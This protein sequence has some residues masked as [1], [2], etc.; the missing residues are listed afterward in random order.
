MTNNSLYP[1]TLFHFT[2]KKWLFDILKE[3][4]KVSYARETIKA[5]NN[6]RKLAVPMVS[7][8]DIKLAEIKYFIEKDYG[9]FGIGLTKDWANRNGLNPVMYINRH[10]DLADKLIDGLNGMYAQISKM[11]NIDD[12]KKMT[13]SY[14]NLM[15]MYRYVKNY[16]GELIRKGNLVDPNYRF[17][18]E[19]E[20][21]FVPPLE[22][23]GVEPFVAISN[24]T[25]KK[26]KEEYNKKVAHIKLTFEPDD[27]K[28]LFV[29]NEN[30]IS[31]LIDHLDYAKSKYS[32]DIRRRLASRILT[33]EQVQNDI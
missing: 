5:P 11:S 29:E 27:I 7:F 23:P 14:H 15:N 17:A 28:Y 3:T 25:T 2:E 19:R 32:N 21:R 6:E 16:E 26:Q 9:N 12:I 20:W 24:I 8:C 30:D 4:F 22:T 33:V 31:E 13:K 18:D 10:C 1:S